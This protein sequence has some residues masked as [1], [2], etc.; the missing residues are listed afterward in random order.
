MGEQNKGK[1]QQKP[2]DENQLKKVRREKLA[3]L[4]EEG[5]NPYEI[6]KYNVTD[7]TADVREKFAQL[8]AAT[9]E[10]E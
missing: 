9:P 6:T 10:G 3:T 4:M 8:E 2:Q 7:H 1:N 5:R